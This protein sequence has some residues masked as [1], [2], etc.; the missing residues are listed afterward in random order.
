M[1][2]ERIKERHENLCDGGEGRFGGGVDFGL[3]ETHDGSSTSAIQ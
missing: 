1:T 2:Y 3:E